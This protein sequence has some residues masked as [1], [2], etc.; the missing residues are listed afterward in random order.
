MK[1]AYLIVITLAVVLL[2]F[3]VPSFAQTNN[4]AQAGNSVQAAPE[5]GFGTTAKVAYSYTRGYGTDR[6]VRVSKFY[7]PSTG[8]Y[9][10][11]PSVPLNLKAIEPTVSI[12]WGYSSGYALLA[13]WID[14][15]VYTN[16]STGELEV[17][18]YDFNAGG[19]PVISSNVAF[20]LVIK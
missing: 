5:A 1:R 3:S 7:S 13:Y 11:A 9:C 17:T 14:T 18:T 20:N 15:S 8:I 2:A 16:C 6:K 12:E 10:I 19:Y 4:A